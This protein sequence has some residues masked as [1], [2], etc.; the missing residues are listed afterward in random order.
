VLIPITTTRFDITGKPVGETGLGD[1]LVLAKYRF[2]RRDSPRGTTQ[3]S[4]TFGPKLP[5]GRTNLADA[6]GG[7]LPASL[8]PGSGS[9]DLFLAGNWTY[10][11][12]FNIKRLVSDEDVHAL[13]PS[14]GTSA[15]RHGRHRE[16]RD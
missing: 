7:L 13:S 3:A 5:T 12:L 2:Y 10:T 15:T 8:Q 16:A 14:Q 9:T 11:G 6:S 1:S 4:A